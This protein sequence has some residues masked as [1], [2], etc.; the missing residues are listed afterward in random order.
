M[1]LSIHKWVRGKPEK[2][3]DS[4]GR[5]YL[6]QNGHRVNLG[7]GW[8]NIEADWSTVFHLIT[9]DGCATSAQLKSNHRDETEFVSR[10]LIMVDIDSGMTITE[11]LQDPYYLEHSAGFYV[12]PSHT[13]TA[14]R[15]RIMFRTAT[16]LTDPVQVKQLVRALMKVFGHAD[17]AC[18]DATRLF[19]GTVNAQQSECR[20][21]VLSDLEVELLTAMIDMFDQEAH[22][23]MQY[24]VEH[25]PLSDLRRQGIIDL[26]RTTFCGQY[27]VWRD[28]GWGMRSGGYSLAD[29]QYVTTAIMNQKSSAD[30]QAIWNS[31]RVDHKPPTLGTVIHYL[32]SHLGPEI[33]KEFWTVT[34]STNTDHI[35]DDR[36][37]IAQSMRQV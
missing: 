3:K 12:T 13:E 1:N 11:L 14:H 17:P 34:R 24:A 15:F 7:Y 31:Y 37:I 23:A 9:V 2:K 4:I 28:I 25:E 30:A 27:P 6:D 32:K 19:Y 16:P 10:E 33:M 35:V 26:L 36:Q 29:F 20:S 21:A 5:D 8:E 22:E 18:K